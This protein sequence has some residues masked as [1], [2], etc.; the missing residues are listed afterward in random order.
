METKPHP[1][2]S[3][4]DL[5][6]VP[7]G[8]VKLVWSSAIDTVTRSV[9]N[10]LTHKIILTCYIYRS[11]CPGSIPMQTLCIRFHS[12]DSNHMFIGT[13]EVSCDL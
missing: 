13:D 1:Q 9:C 8:R 5:G 10:T 7:N 12:T 11:L 6:L 3:E 2:G 4:S